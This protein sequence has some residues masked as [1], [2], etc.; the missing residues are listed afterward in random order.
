MSQ[1]EGGKFLEC[2][3]RLLD[4]YEKEKQKK[5]Q[6]NCKGGSVTVLGTTDKLGNR[7]LTDALSLHEA[8]NH[9]YCLA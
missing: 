4:P 8:I 7:L 1:G 2:I 5:R 9:D 6:K 3:D